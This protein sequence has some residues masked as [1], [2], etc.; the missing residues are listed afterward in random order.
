M[1]SGRDIVCFANDWRSDPTSKKHV[2][3]R[4]ARRNRVLWVN[5]IGCRNPRATGRDLARLARK[6]AAAARDLARGGRPVEENLW[7]AS[8]VAVP[9]H[10]NRLARR[11]N[12]TFLAAQLRRAARRLGMRDLVTWSFVPTSAGVAGALGERLLVYH[13]V[14]EFSRFTGVDATALVALE[15]ELA[16]R[17]DLV[18]VSSEPLYESKR[19]LNPNTHVVRHGV[20]VE[21]FGR[22]LAPETAIPADLPRGDGPVVGFFGALADWVDFELVRDLARARPGFTFAL[23]GAVECDVSAIDGLSNVHRLGWRSYGELPGYCKGFDVAILPFRSNEL[24][25]AANPLKLREYLAAGLPVVSTALPEAERL[26]PEVR[27]G[28]DREEFLRELDACLAGG[29]AAAGPRRERAA[30][31]AAESWDHK[32]EEMCALVAPLLAA[33]ASGSLPARAGAAVGERPEATA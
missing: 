12:R 5:S 25:Y 18:L 9:F 27:I 6:A 19:R 21:H 14:D 2:M 33:A 32:T 1:L 29:I 23:V 24:T 20:E 10:G 3:R 30:R 22:A 13:C 15:A 16:A 11:F 4:L 8:P 28:R 17:A 7:V 26:R 31:V